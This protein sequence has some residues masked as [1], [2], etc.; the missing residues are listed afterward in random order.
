QGE[1]RLNERPIK[2]LVDALRALGADIKYLEKDGFAP[3]EITGKNL[4][5][6]TISIDG[7]R[8]SQFITAMMLIAPYCDAPLVFTIDQNQVSMPYI[9][10]TLKLMQMAGAIV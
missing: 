10:M 1:A 5:G 2:E 9:N 3:V 8:S 4:A 7:S 6:G